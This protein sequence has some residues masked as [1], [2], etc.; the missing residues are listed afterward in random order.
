MDSS[1]LMVL[2]QLP[3]AQPGTG[4][5]KSDFNSGIKDKSSD[6]EL[7]FQ[8]ILNSIGKNE[9]KEK[10]EKEPDMKEIKNKIDEIEKKIDSLET[11][12]KKSK[13]PE[14][15]ESLKSILEKIKKMIAAMK[16]KNND[17]DIRPGK[18]GISLMSFI[19]QVLEQL[20]TIL[21]KQGLNGNLPALELLKK[22]LEGIENPGKINETS[23]TG[24][25]VSNNQQKTQGN[26]GG[27]KDLTQE[28]VVVIDKR[29]K[30]EEAGKAVLNNDKGK[31][32]PA[33]QFSGLG[34]MKIETSAVKTES[35]QP[36]KIIEKETGDKSVVKDF[37]A[38]GNNKTE[39]TNS[40]A[41]TALNYSLPLNRAGLEALMQN[42]TGRALVTLRDGKSEMR[43]NL[44]PPE[45]GRMSMKFVLEGGRMT[46][47]IV[48]S[49][50][51]AKMIFDQN[52][53]DL[54]RS[55]QQAGINIGNLNVSLSG[56]GQENSG[57]VPEGSVNNYY[58][59]DITVEQPDEPENA[60]KSLFE[61][62]IN[63]LA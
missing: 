60:Y 3:Q 63:Y 24:V 37:A 21:D 51:E 15:L 41:R 20:I 26:P 49:T 22:K 8:D 9:N 34:S 14:E 13:D 50:P 11:N 43:M 6:R 39:M 46:G 23:E 40:P 48:V 54:Q 42:V 56:D 29:T 12:T 44:I 59:G 7:S 4:G 55:L 58:T 38:Q 27:E 10:K 19:N 28:K 47:Q 52:L 18:S 45:L 1:N 17:L 53:G 33:G 57:Q 16:D 62:S 32:T 36:I 30:P 31:N 2:T 5:L 61:S 25:K 35:S